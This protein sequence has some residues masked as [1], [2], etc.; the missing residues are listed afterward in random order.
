MKNFNQ[1]Q[2]FTQ[3]ECDYMLSFGTQYR[4]HNRYPQRGISVQESHIR[5]SSN[6]ELKSF[7]VN[8]F[9]EH[10]EL[11]DIHY[12]EMKFIKYTEGA[13]F[14][15]HVDSASMKNS[16]QWPYGAYRTI[17]IMMN[18]GSKYR[19][20]DLIMHGDGEKTIADK[21][22]GNVLFYD[23]DIPHEVTKV[24]YGTRISCLI[25]LS[26]KDFRFNIV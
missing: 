3:D 26:K 16:A 7:V 22:V 10:F 4:P 17:V 6:P 19:G 9:Y 8:K 5:L 21:T 12:D 15:L 13:G 11:I 25:L 23:S 2:V 14:G 1:M 18:D 20:G 24:T